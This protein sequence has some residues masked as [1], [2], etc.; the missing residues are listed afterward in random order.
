MIHT[1]SSC[2]AKN[3]IPAA[4]LANSGKCGSCS[5]LFG[6]TAD[7][8]DVRSVAEFDEIVAATDVPILVDFWAEWCGPCRTAA[9]EVKKT[10]AEVAGQGLVL[11]I[12]TMRLGDLASRYGV[13]GIPNF[14]VFKDGKL[15]FQQAGL[16][17]SDAMVN[18]IRQAA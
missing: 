5:T 13:Q 11:K 16:V 9:P 12:D 18:W 1:C 3:R 17:R 6:P 2:S 8:I 14:A 15:T 7:P 10:A 4:H